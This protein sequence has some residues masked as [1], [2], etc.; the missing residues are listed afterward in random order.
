MSNQNL[1]LKINILAFLLFYSNLAICQVK[2]PDTLVVNSKSGKIIL[3]SDSITNFKTVNVQ[4]II[5]KAIDQIQDS[6]VVTDSTLKK[7]TRLPKDSIYT[8]VLKNKQTFAFQVK[9][10]GA[11]AAG[12]FTPELG[13]GIDFAPQRQ[14]FYYKGST[15]P[16]YTFINLSLSSLW[17]FEKP[18][19]EV[20]EIYRNIFL[21]ASF[22]NRINNSNAT[23]VRLIDEFSF[24]AGYLIQQ[25]GNYFEQNTL[26]LFVTFLPKNSFIS[27][28]PEMYFYDNY[29]FS[30]LG[31]SMRFI[32][33]VGRLFKP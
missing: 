18:N 29:K 14:D 5:N 22:G 25:R 30:Y 6:L 12:R 3:I 11:F 16:N 8:K 9:A 10:G 19:N 24:G 7:K 33:P 21:E 13:F 2:T 31:L 15:Q 17:F 20:P 32:S 28:K 27:F 1:K 4:S 26:K 23:G